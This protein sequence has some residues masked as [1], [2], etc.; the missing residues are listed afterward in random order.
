MHTWMTSTG[1][2]GLWGVG[3]L[4]DGHEIPVSYHDIEQD[5]LAAGAALDALGVPADAN[6]LLLSTLP[7][8]ATVW[9]FAA[10]A[11][12]GSRAVYFADATTFDANRTEMF[13]RRLDIDAILGVTQAVVDGLTELGDPYAVLARARIVAA[14]PTL[15][16]TLQAH[17]VNAVTWLTLGPA[18]ALECAHG[19]LHV[20][21]LQWEVTPHPHGLSVT[22][23]PTRATAPA[24]FETPVLGAPDPVSCPCGLGGRLTLEAHA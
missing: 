7:G 16:P 8:V 19:S 3:F 5:T 12:R 23:A 15:V 18:L 20:D 1:A 14:E 21:P 2:A 9:P 10:A 11:A 4:P 13:T 24:T 22:P 6:I 17:G